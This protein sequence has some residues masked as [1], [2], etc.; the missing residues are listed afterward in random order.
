MNKF[1]IYQYKYQLHF[2]LFL[3][4]FIFLYN[5]PIVFF[6]FFLFL[7]L[8]FFIS[9]SATF[10]T[11][12]LVKVYASYPAEGELARVDVLRVSSLLA[13][14]P[15]VRELVAYPGPLIKQV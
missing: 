11:G 4:L 10:S 15:V 7:F 13:H 6:L 3:L 12:S 9:F 14:D 5:F 1:L 2:S 8:V